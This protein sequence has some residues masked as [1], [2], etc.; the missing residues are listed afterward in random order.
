MLPKHKLPIMG[1]LK[2]AERKGIEPTSICCVSTGFLSLNRSICHEYATTFSCGIF[3]HFI[4][5]DHLAEGKGFEPISVR[6]VSAWLF[7]FYFYSAMNLPQ[8]YL[9]INLTQ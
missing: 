5:Q 4:S 6:S 7:N 9:L 1:V 3:R 8:I 2:V